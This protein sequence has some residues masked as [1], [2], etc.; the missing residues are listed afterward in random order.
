MSEQDNDG[1]RGLIG[2]V[3]TDLRAIRSRFLNPSAPGDVLLSDITTTALRFRIAAKASALSQPFIELRI[4]ELETIAALVPL[5]EEMRLRLISDLEV[6]LPP[7]CER[8]DL[9]GVPWWGDAKVVDS[10]LES[11]GPPDSDEVVP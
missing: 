11:L 9:V 4:A 5:K 6:M 1:A 3:L 10:V 8:Q 7:C 2:N